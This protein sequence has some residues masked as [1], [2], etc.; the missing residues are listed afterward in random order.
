M[1]FVT[2]NSVCKINMG[3]SP[4]SSS[5]N[6]D[7]RG[8]PFFQGNADFGERYPITRIWCDA[9]AKIAQANDILISVRAPIGAVNYAYE[10]CCIG[11]GLAAITPD[12][13]AVSTEFI[14][15]LLK[16]RNAEL[17]SKGTGSTFK[18]IGRKILE[19]VLVPAI[20][21]EQQ[22]AYANNLEA[23]F[24]IIQNRKAQLASLDNLIKARFVEL[25]GD[26]EFNTKGWPVQL[27][28]RLCEVGSSKR[29]YQNEQSLEGVPFWR[30]SD[31]VSKMDTGL[32]DS[33]L[34]IPEGKY[35]ELK[36]A[37]L[38]P[39]AGDILVTSRG[40]LGRCYII[41]NEDRFYFQ[42]GMI[43]W[44]SDYKDG[45]TPLYLKH[46]FTM[47]GF[48]KQIDSMQAGSTVAYLSIA[49]LKKLRVMVPD[50][51]LQED[52]ALFIAQ[53]DKSKFAIQKSLEET[54]KLFDSLMQQYFG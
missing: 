18:A 36:K 42:D 8:L 31:L 41:K 53:S 19:E 12:N 25:F 35:S 44:L 11:R 48:R 1:N 28:D 33:G 27:L 22:A 2:L 20:R 10:K 51:E 21:F 49:M 6:S 30:I 14:Y 7:G 47:P 45:I 50:I 5:Y 26:P 32:V 54:Q 52:F 39:V 24:R 3:Q 17:N 34:F 40:T 38:V 46:L 15:W 37:G 29:I 9:P 43:S 13:T 23:V 4:E 16:A